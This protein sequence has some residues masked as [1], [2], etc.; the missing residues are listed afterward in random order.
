MDASLAQGERDFYQMA[1]PQE[2]ERYVLRILAIKAVLRDP[3]WRVNV[4]G[5]AMRKRKWKPYGEK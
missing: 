3:T 4:Q 1:L 2:T 5:S